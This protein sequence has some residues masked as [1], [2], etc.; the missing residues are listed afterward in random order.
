VPG[1]YEEMKFSHRLRKLRKEN[2]LTQ[3]DLAEQINVDRATIAGYETKGKEPAYDKLEKLANYFNVSID[4]LLGRSDIKT[5]EEHLQKL[6]KDDPE[7][8]EIL[9]DFKNDKDRLMTFKELRKLD[10]E[11]LKEILNIIKSFEKIHGN[12]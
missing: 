11:S 12:N 2:N 5:P 3:K 10:N 1:R 6:F 4:Y 7:L 8:V 9:E